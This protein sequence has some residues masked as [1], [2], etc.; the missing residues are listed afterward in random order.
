VEEVEGVVMVCDSVGEG[1]VVV[2]VLRDGQEMR[3]LSLDV[4][5]LDI[6]GLGVVYMKPGI[7]IHQHVIHEQV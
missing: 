1:E 3:R 5:E 7:E 2:V 4:Y 6:A